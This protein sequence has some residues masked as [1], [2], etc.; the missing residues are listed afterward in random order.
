LTSQVFCLSLMAAMRCVNLARDAPLRA[1][2]GMIVITLLSSSKGVALDE[3]AAGDA[4]AKA[5]AGK[6]DNVARRGSKGVVIIDTFLFIEDFIVS[7]NT[8]FV[9]W[10]TVETVLSIHRQSMLQTCG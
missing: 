9:A 8:A 4:A 7:V 2:K 1:E 10:H 3:L 6:V 5:N